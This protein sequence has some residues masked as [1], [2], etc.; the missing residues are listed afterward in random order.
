MTAVE[1]FKHRYDAVVQVIAKIF[2]ARSGLLLVAS[3]IF[4]SLWLTTV[5][6]KVVNSGF[7]FT[8]AEREFSKLIVVDLHD[9]KCS[10]TIFTCMVRWKLLSSAFLNCILAKRISR[11]IV[12]ANY[13]YG[14][15]QTTVS[16]KALRWSK[17]CFDFRCTD[18]NRKRPAA[19]G[20]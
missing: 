16:I 9:E 5:V 7:G 6:Y 11:E 4:S 20:R 8:L 1:N 2:P 19:V 12:L 10:K 18:I 3:G 15:G 13:N 17:G 14:K